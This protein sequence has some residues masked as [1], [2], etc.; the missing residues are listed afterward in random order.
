MDGRTMMMIY[1]T[2]TT[3]QL[4]WNGVM[5][6]EWCM[7]S[8]GISYSI[9]AATAAAIAAKKDKGRM[10]PQTPFS[11]AALWGTTTSTRRR[12]MTISLLL[13]IKSMGAATVIVLR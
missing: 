6:I 10:A 12:A 2:G 3:K 9:A 7:F 11:A 4:G 13:M 8:G 5:M 1:K